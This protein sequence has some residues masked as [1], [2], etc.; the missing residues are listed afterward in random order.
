MFKELQVIKEKNKNKKKSL[1]E[2][3]NETFAALPWRFCKSW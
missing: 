2:D 1:K 3:V